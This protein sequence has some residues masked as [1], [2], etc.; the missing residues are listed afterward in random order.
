MFLYKKPIQLSNI[1]IIPLA[2]KM[3]DYTSIVKDLFYKVLDILLKK[4]TLTFIIYC[5]WQTCP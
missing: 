4:I 5:D 2:K 3:I 1:F